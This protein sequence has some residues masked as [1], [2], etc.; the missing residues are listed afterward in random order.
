MIEGMGVGE[1]F[2][3]L[4]FDGVNVNLGGFVVNLVGV[5]SGFF[6]IFVGW[7]VGIKDVCVLIGFGW[8]VGVV[9]EG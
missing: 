6:V 2:I 5:V 3:G 4:I 1:M 7:L 9:F 8:F